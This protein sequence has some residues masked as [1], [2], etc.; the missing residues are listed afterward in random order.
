MGDLLVR[1]AFH[2]AQ[3]KHG[4]ELWRQCREGSLDLGATLGSLGLFA[5]IVG[6]CWLR[7]LHGVGFLVTE[8]QEAIEPTAPLAEMVG[9]PAGGDGMQPGGEFGF[10]S[11][12]GQFLP[13]GQP[14]FLAHIAG[15]RLVADNRVNDPE[16]SLV[17]VSHERAKSG[18]TPG[19]CLPQDFGRGFRMRRLGVGHGQKGQQG[20][21]AGSVPGRITLASNGRST[22]TRL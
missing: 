7:N 17:V 13:H 8:R 21:Q 19:L 15:I 1:K 10:A 5:G 20:A 11:E 6:R 3:G 22:C 14:D 4:A 2:L 18:F 9:R 16:D 12:F